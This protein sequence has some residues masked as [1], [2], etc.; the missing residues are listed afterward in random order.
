[1]SYLQVIRHIEQ[2]LNSY[3]DPVRFT[4]T[5][6]KLLNAA[7]TLMAVEVMRVDIL[8]RNECF[9][10]PPPVPAYARNRPGRYAVNIVHIPPVLAEAYSASRRYTDAELEAMIRTSTSL[11]SCYLL[12]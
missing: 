9:A 3:G 10:L 12:A 4:P 5:G 1:M 8:A 7:G 6:R 2:A 11:F